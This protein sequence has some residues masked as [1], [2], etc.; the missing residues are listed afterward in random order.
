M[1]HLGH[2]LPSLLHL[3]LLNFDRVEFDHVDHAATE[4][5]SPLL[6]APY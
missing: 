3:N 6:V 5:K 1:L 4:I 2:H